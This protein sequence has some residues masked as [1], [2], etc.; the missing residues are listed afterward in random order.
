MYIGRNSI[1][2]LKA[3]IDG[4][5]FRNSNGVS[6]MHIMNDFQDWVEKK[7]NVS[8]SHS[9]CDVLLFYSQDESSA[10]SKFFDEFEVWSNDSL[11]LS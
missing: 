4:W 6:D 2:C 11:L 9:W 7:Y 5:Y 8:T 3:F 10:L 1:S